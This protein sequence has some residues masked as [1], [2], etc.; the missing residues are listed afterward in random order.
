MTDLR[1][2]DS[3]IMAHL[4]TL[5]ERIE[6]TD[7]VIRDVVLQS[8]RLIDRPTAARLMYTARRDR[9]SFFDNDLF[10]EPAWDILLD[11]YIAHS[12]D[13]PISVSSAGIAACA[14]PTTGLR[15]VAAL[16]ERGLVERRQ[17]EKDR[18][19]TY[20]MLTDQGVLAMERFLDRYLANPLTRAHGSIGR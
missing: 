11:L 10:G 14:P 2:T 8:A 4:K 3:T 5:T 20:V 18:R 16:V 17:D 1:I 9:D 12:E 15:W 7:Q 13:R 19:V 6:A